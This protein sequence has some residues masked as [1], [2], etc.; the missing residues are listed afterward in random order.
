[1]ERYLWVKK[2]AAFFLRLYDDIKM[3]FTAFKMN[4]LLE[5]FSKLELC[6]VIRFF[7]R[8]GDNASA[9]HCKI[10]EMYGNRMSVEMVW[11]W[12][13]QFLEGGTDEI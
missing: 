6:S 5:M 13:K 11:R 8:R 2:Y 7:T 4:L 1:M 9:I 12:R 10:T 3:C